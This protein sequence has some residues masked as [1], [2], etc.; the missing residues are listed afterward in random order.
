M[1][2][3]TTVE[4]EIDA[5]APAELFA[6]IGS[7]VSVVTVTLFPTGVPMSPNALMTS[8]NVAVEPAGSAPTVPVTVPVEPTA[9]LVSVKIGPD[10]CTI[11]A[12]APA[13]G[14]VSAKLTVCASLG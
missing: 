2:R 14:S 5:A 8:E 9:G 4:A 1:I 12:N 3:G 13:A 7:D 10:V 6:T 11:E